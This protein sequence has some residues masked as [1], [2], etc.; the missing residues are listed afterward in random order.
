MISSIAKIVSF[1][2][3]FRTLEP[4]VGVGMG[5]K[6]PVGLQAGDVMARGFDGLSEQRQV[7]VAF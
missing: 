1:V 6:P 4:G 3:E 2:I 7:V 5:M